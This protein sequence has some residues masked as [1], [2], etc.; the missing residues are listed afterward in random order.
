MLKLTLTL[1]AALESNFGTILAHPEVKAGI[2]AGTSAVGVYGMMPATMRDLGEAD[3]QV[4]AKKLAK[5]ILER[6]KAY[7]TGYL[8]PMSPCPFI[9]AVVLWERGPRHR[10]TPETWK[11]K[12]VTQRLKRARMVWNPIKRGKYWNGRSFL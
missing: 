2:H 9:T 12:S 5:R 7:I 6:N 11:T 3:D 10:I 8:A 4:A 1:I